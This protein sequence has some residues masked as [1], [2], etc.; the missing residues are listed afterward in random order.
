MKPDNLVIILKNVREK[1]GFSVT[2]KKIDNNNLYEYIKRTIGHKE[3]TVQL[4]VTL[5][6]YNTLSSL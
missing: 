1:I 5:L 4:I 2:S 3:I 6:K